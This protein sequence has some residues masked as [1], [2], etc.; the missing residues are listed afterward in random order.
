MPEPGPNTGENES[1]GRDPWLD[2]LL[3]AVSD[4]AM[5]FTPEGK[6][7]D[8]NPAAVEVIEAESVAAM[9]GR[10]LEDLIAVEDQGVAA[11]AK[12]LLASGGRGELQW[13]TAGNKGGRRK[14]KF[15]VA[16][17]QQLDGQPRASI[18]IGREFA[19]P[20]D[21][22]LTSIVASSADAIVSLDLAENIT[23]WNPAAQQLFGFTAQ[24]AIGRPAPVL[25]CPEHLRGQALETID[26]VT[27]GEGPF[28]Y[29]SQRQ[30]KMA[31]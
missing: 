28:H 23:A 9:R 12:K 24:E 8:A 27:R 18:I 10:P 20:S 11:E 25:L 4:P 19:P 14:L 6:L 16:P 13:S 3:E 22:L 1:A 2:A 26:Q 29:E 7:L 31:A 17:L 21:E 30:K 5:V 15:R